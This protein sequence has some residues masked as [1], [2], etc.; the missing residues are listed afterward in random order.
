MDIFYQVW[1]IET[2]YLMKLMYFGLNFFNVILHKC[3]RW[4]LV[5]AGWERTKYK[6]YFGILLAVVILNVA[7][8]CQYAFSSLTVVGTP[9]HENP[10]KTATF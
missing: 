3:Q 10:S 9:T 8:W 2:N 7:F 1:M 5:L 6:K 4:A